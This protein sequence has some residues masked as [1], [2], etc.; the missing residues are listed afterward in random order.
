MMQDK[1]ITALIAVITVLALAASGVALFNSYDSDSGSVDK[2]TLYF[3]LGES[4][5]NTDEIEQYIQN[6]I[7]SE[8]ITGYTNF[9]AEGGSHVDGS[10]LKDDVTLVFCIIDFDKNLG[11]FDSL[12]K[13]VKDKY[14]IAKVLVEKQKINAN[15]I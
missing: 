1:T 14:G 5:A 11:N 8:Y 10:V 9:R 12:I 3:G 2:Y 7:I 4:P 6:K 15:L 13:D